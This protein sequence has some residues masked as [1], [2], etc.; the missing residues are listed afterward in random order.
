M[1]YLLKLQ[2]WKKLVL[3]NIKWPLNNWKNSLPINLSLKTKI[4]N[5]LPSACW[6]RADRWVTTVSILRKSSSSLCW[7]R[8]M[9]LRWVEAFFY[10]LMLSYLKKML[11][12]RPVKMPKSARSFLPERTIVKRP[13]LWL[14]ASKRTNK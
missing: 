5:V 14:L 7:R 6:T 8:K 1:N 11:F 2:N 9:P 3:P 13:F 4:S 10:F 12:R